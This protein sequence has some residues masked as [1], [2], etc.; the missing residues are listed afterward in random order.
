ML[1]ILPVA[2]R[3]IAANIELRD[4]TLRLFLSVL[5]LVVA[6]KIAG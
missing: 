2:T 4:L 3:S 5:G 1:H 6:L